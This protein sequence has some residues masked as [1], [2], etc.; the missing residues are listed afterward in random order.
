[1]SPRVAKRDRGE[2]PKPM[3]KPGLVGAYPLKAINL[4]FLVTGH[5]DLVIGQ[6]DMPETLYLKE[7]P[8]LAIL[9]GTGSKSNEKNT[10]DVTGKIFNGFADAFYR[11]K[12]P[13][14]FLAQ[15]DAGAIYHFLDEFMDYLEKLYSLGFFLAKGLPEDPMVDPVDQYIPCF[16]IAS[17][18]IFYNAFLKK[19]AESIE[20]IHHVSDAMERKIL[21][22][23]CRGIITPGETQ[24]YQQGKPIHVEAA[25]RIKIAGGG[26]VTQSTSRSILNSH[27]FETTIEN[28]ADNPIERIEFENALIRS[29]QAIIPALT[30][31]GRLSDGEAKDYQKRIQENIFLIG[32]HRKAF[33]EKESLEAIMMEF[34]ETVMTKGGKSVKPALAPSLIPGDASILSTL[35]KYAES[36]NLHEEKEGFQEL[37]LKVNEHLKKLP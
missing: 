1:M 25:K 21:A 14:I 26:S 35:I 7:R 11:G 9:D 2:P 23:F 15:P 24:L 30:Q 4:S 5:C 19:L 32:K 28:K 31:G 22:K 12:L 6:K 37:K 3:V 18:G 13:Q 33:E 34:P 36:L 20:N 29:S 17:N 10:V 8:T 27:G 16:V